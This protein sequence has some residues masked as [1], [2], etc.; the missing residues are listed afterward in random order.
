MK[1]IIHCSILLV[2]L[3]ACFWHSDV[4]AGHIYKVDKVHTQ[5][6]GVNT[7]Q[8][9]R[10]ALAQGK[11]EAFDIIVRRVTLSSSWDKLPDNTTL[12]IED[13]IDS[14]QIEQE[15]TAPSSYRATLSV[16][17]KPDALRRLLT[18]QGLLITD[19]QAPPLIVIPVF[20]AG[21]D[22]FLWQN[23]IWSA[24][25]EKQDL[26][27][28]NMP[29]ILPFDALVEEQKVSYTRILSGDTDAINTLRMQ[30]N[31]EKIMIAHAFSHPDNVLDLEAYLYV[32]YMDG[33]LDKNSLTDIFVKS[34]Q[35]STQDASAARA[36][37]ELLF[38]LSESWK[39]LSVVNDDH[40]SQLSV[41]VI[42]R[43]LPEWHNLKLRM[44]QVNFMRH[45][46][47]EQVS[48]TSSNV[49]LNF[50]GSLMQLKSSLQQAGLNLSHDIMS[51]MW[52]LKAIK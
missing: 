15:K 4:R 30:L 49:T 51:D 3:G 52:Y 6:S 8:A 20:S 47:I 46:I 50:V 1:S 16:S 33:T 40:I 32:P 27:N 5:A 10:Y 31:A 39:Q 23:N 14:F 21:E 35:G 28:H 37:R 43:T 26:L 42:Y 36:V 45:I 48:A 18:M 9:R 22:D 25:W 11:R 44:E 17:F 13:Y 19:V 2:S 41:S 34:Y 29:I 12:N 38:T 24:Q 7:A